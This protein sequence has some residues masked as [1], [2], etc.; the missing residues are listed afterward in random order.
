MVFTVGTHVIAHAQS[1]SRSPRAGVI[2]QV[3]RGDPS[4]RYRVRWDDGHESLYT[5]ASGNLQAQPAEDSPEPNDT[6]A[7][8]R[9]RRYSTASGHERA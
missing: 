9:S 1:T 6:A 2:E 3:L 7:A 5:P 4:P 8:G